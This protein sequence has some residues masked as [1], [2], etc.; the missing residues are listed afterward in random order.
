MV[1]KS[2]SEFGFQSESNQFSKSNWIW[3][4]IWLEF[5]QIR[6]LDFSFFGRVDLDLKVW[7][8]LDLDL[9]LNLAG[10]ARLCIT[11]LSPNFILTDGTEFGPH[12][13]SRICVSQIVPNIGRNV[14][15]LHSAV[16]HYPLHGIMSTQMWKSGEPVSRVH[17]NITLRHSL[18]IWL[19]L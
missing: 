8:D 13:F 1:G 10:F 18:T 11:G 3:I 5:F 14:F 9:D 7:P 2:R 4:W 15:P 19:I 6:G 17:D 12:L 16:S